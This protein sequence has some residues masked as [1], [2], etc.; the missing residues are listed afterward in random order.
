[1]IL[2]LNI[3]IFFPADETLEKTATANEYSQPYFKS[4]LAVVSPFYQGKT[5]YGGA[6]SSYINQ[7]NIKFTK[8]THINNTTNN[9][10]ATMS[11]STKRIMDL[12]DNFSSP[13]IEARRI[14]QIITSPV[15]N[16]NQSLNSTGTSKRH[17]CM[18]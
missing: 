2:L 12:L 16:T 13:T 14:P 9:N 7:P 5:K 18:Y 8:T 15:N 6:S 17:L 1:M 11:N 3:S 4:S 10:D